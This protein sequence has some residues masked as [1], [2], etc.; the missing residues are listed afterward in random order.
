MQSQRLAGVAAATTSGLLTA[1]GGV[2]TYDTTVTITYCVNNKAATKTAVTT[3]AT[4]TTDSATGAAAATLTANK[5]RVVVWGLISGGTVVC[6]HG[7]NT[8]LDSSG[9][10]LT[11]P[12]F[13]D[14]PD[15]VAPFAYQV[16][17][18]GSTAGTITFGTSNWNATGF[19]NTIQNVIL[20]LPNR[21]QTA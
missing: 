17:K 12:Q 3:G 15:T 4:P 14:V 1:I 16:L 5:G 6:Y 7:K 2:T 20:G 11:A 8:D 9:S 13:P 18:A 21:P 10:F 19:T